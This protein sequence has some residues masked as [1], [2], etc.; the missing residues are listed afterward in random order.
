MAKIL[1]QLGVVV[2]I[3]VAGYGGW[4]VWNQSQTGTGGEEASGRPRSAP[5]VVV[6]PAQ[7]A[8]LERTVAA[9]GTGRPVRSVE[10][11]PSAGGRVIEIGFEGGDTVKAGDV[12]L[13]LDGTNEQATLT[14]AQA[15]L[16]RAESAFRRQ[17]TLKEQGRVTEINME[18]AEAD[19]SVAVAVLA[20]AE[21][22]LADKTLLAPFD[23]TVGFRAVD[24]G[25]LITN[26]TSIA[27]LDDLSALNVDFSIPER[28]YGE[29]ALGDE[30]RATTEIFPGE[31]FDG[32]LI[33]IGRSIDTV[34]RSFTARARIENP[35]ARLPA[36][37]FMRVTLV[38]ESREGTVVPEEAVSAEGGAL[39][40][41]V[42]ADEKA[43]R[44]PVEIGIRSAGQAEIRDGVT[45]GE[46]V[47][48]RG[49]QK[50]RDGA[51]VSIIDAPATGS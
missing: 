40:V 17:Q 45:A 38:L 36:D 19:R 31:A 37:V 41:Y 13:R 4:H 44:R 10:L 29:V 28:F 1:T 32:R 11:V 22:A 7:I 47:V 39:Y 46:M 20:R 24:I 33:S 8:P 14:E 51:A 50:V 27:T 5:G 15:E 26:S 25:A 35:G 43:E 34:S 18:N 6:T 3:A 42:V 21:K 30:I 48:T 23:G 49:L 9:V 2:A 16:A 12:L